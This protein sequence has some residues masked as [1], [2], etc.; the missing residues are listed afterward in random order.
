MQPGAGLETLEPRLLLS[1]AS[2]L[3]PPGVG[4]A[5]EGSRSGHFVIQLD[6]PAKTDTAVRFVLGGTAKNGR[7][8]VKVIK[9]T[10]IPAGEQYAVVEINPI[11]NAKRTK[12]RTVTLKLA[13]GKGYTIDSASKRGTIQIYDETSPRNGGTFTALAPTTTSIQIDPDSFIFDIRWFGAAVDG[14]TDDTTAVNAAIAAAQKIGGTVYFPAGVCRCDGRVIIQITGGSGM[15]D[16]PIQTSMIFRGEGDCVLG[17]SSNFPTSPSGGSILDLRW[18]GND[19]QGNTGLAKI[20]ARGFG[21]LEICNL[22]L[23]D[24]SP[25]GTTNPF[26]AVT[27]TTVHIHDT[28]F[29]GNPSK[30]GISC[31]QDAITLGGKDF[32]AGPD[33]GLLETSPFQGYG[34]TIENCF[35]N[36]I[37]RAVR[38]GY[39]CNGVLIE[40]N[41]VSATCGT[42]LPDGACIE[43]DGDGAVDA[44]GKPTPYVVA[45]AGG[46]ISGNN[47]QVGGYVYGI[48]LAHSLNWT[49]SG[50]GFYGADSAA[51]TK[52]YIRLEN[53]ARFNYIAEGYGDTTNRPYV[54]EDTPGYNTIIATNFYRVTNPNTTIFIN[55]VMITTSLDLTGATV[56]G[57]EQPVDQYVVEDQEYG[58]INYTIPNTGVDS[59]YCDNNEGHTAWICLPDAA[60][61]VPGKRIFIKRQSTGMVHINGWGADTIDNMDQIDLKTKFDSLL[62]ERDSPDSWA[63]MYI[64]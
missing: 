34:T 47:I 26:L 51:P 32:T 31:D 36:R 59:V 40:N 64:S 5:Y 21:K 10:E 29:W 14:R 60:S 33:W 13:R 3:V 17:H 56:I 52:A 2:I 44:S 22:T 54:S 46:I 58:D 27:N 12:D 57:Y 6:Q 15:Y 25:D 4:D 7:S 55:P 24:R 23:T 35:F 16:P 18:N 20:A 19:G 61:V 1:Q 50:D 48:K 37:R 8:Y 9:K 30:S 39:Y 62:V 43:I 53:Y 28:T 11:E 63:I 42:N 38:G 45:S 41:T 49:L